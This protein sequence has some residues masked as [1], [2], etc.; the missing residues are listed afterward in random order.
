MSRASKGFGSDP[1]RRP[2]G[3]P[4]SNSW[5]SSPKQQPAPEKQAKEPEPKKPERAGGWPV[6]E[7]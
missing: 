7:D 4:G 1:S 5:G 2:P 6:W 3:E